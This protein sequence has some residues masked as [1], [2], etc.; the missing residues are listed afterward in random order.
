M[1]KNTVH[2]IHDE[3]GGLECPEKFNK[4][5]SSSDYKNKIFGSTSV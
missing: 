3:S 5:N 1:T 2:R 4:G